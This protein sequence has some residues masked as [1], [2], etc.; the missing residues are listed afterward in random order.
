MTATNK[1]APAEARHE[2]WSNPAAFVDV[3]E[4]LSR[5]MIYANE[6]DHRGRA[7]DLLPRQIIEDADGALRKATGEPMTPDSPVMNEIRRL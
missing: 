7:I 4:A 2:R 6:G 3:C 1:Q 5:M